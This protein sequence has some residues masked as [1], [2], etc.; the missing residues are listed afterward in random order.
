MKSG[1]GMLNSILDMKK[2]S[3]L[4]FV[5]LQL[6]VWAQQSHR[7]NV[8][9]QEKYVKAISN[10]NDTLS[11]NNYLYP[12]AGLK[13]P[14]GKLSIMPVAGDERPARSKPIHFKNKNSI[15]VIQIRSFLVDFYFKEKKITERDKM[16][17][18]IFKED[19]KIVLQIIYN[20]NI[21]DTIYFV[22][23][24][25]DYYFKNLWK[26]LDYLYQMRHAK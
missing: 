13:D 6:N 15:Q 2:Q 1:T 11:D 19:N 25:N 17:A 12:I 4:L 16:T 5:L 21:I 7:S 23:H 22:N 26:D 9:I 24:H 14:F 8:W 20:T 18:Y 10:K 3:T